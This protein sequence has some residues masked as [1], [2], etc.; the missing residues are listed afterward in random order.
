MSNF[1]CCY[2]KEKNEEGE[3]EVGYTYHFSLKRKL[4]HQNRKS[5]TFIK[6]PDGLWYHKFLGGVP[7]RKEEKEILGALEY[8][9]QRKLYAFYMDNVYLY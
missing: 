3:E 5:K 7:T 9:R 6:A 1:Y 8:L 4:L 2:Y